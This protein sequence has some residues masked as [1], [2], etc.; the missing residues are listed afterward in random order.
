MAVAAS[1]TFATISVLLARVPGLTSRAKRVALG[2]R[3]CN[4]P[5]HFDPSS[6]FMVVTPVMLPPGLFRATTSPALTGSLPVVNTIGIVAVACLAA[7]AISTGPVVAI[8]ATWRRTRSATR[9]GNLSYWLFAHRYSIRTSRPST[10]PASLSPLRNAVARSVLVAPSLRNPITG[11]AG[12]CARAASGHAVAAPP[13]SVM[14]S[15]R[16]IR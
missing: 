12:C 6:A 8:T 13:S 7:N 1:C 9:E 2:S 14:N 15:R 16:L 3:S 11:M 10:K 4:S 5:T